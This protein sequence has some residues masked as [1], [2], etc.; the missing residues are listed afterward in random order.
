MV[1][2]LPVV[3]LKIHHGSLGIARSLG[4]LG[5]EVHGLTATPAAPAP[6]ALARTTL[7]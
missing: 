3:V 6:R 5:V 2:S 7:P 4:R 1:A